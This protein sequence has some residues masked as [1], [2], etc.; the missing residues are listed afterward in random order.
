MYCPDSH[1]SK[2]PFCNVLSYINPISHFKMSWA[3]LIHSVIIY[4]PELLNP[5]SHYTLSW[6]KWI[7]SISPYLSIPELPPIMSSLHTF[8]LKLHRVYF[9]IVS[10]TL[11]ALPSSCYM[12]CGSLICGLLQAHFIRPYFGQT[13]SP[14]ILTLVFSVIIF[15]QIFKKKQ[16]FC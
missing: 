6:A 1:K 16:K 5:V 15:S 4:C 11:C 12:L 10:W 9:R 14:A 7:L 13:F 8:R 2:L 3:T